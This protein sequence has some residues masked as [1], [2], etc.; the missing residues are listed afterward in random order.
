MSKELEAL[1]NI[2]RDLEY[3]TRLDYVDPIVRG[4]VRDEL[5][6]I[7]HRELPE[8]DI[9][10]TALKNYE[11][12]T[13]KPAMLY[14]RTHGHT[15]VLIDTICKNYKEV[16]ITNLEDEKKLKALEIIKKYPRCSL[17]R[18]IGFNEMIKE[19]YE[20]TQEHLF[21]NDMPCSVEE[22]KLVV[23]VLL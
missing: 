14:G 20:L 11:E 16:K 22:Y 12:L 4:E 3:I 19:G 21:N 5:Y 6:K 18:Y 15:Q 23:E 8:L 7:Y 17:Q 1:E 2:K 10:E 9:I 13:S